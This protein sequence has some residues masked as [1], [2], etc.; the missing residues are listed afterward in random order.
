MR[1]SMAG[2]GKTI[3]L[4]TTSGE[5]WQF[6]TGKMDNAKLSLDDSIY[7]GHD[8]TPRK[9]RQIVIAGRAAQTGLS[10]N[11]AMK[12]MKRN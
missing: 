9:A 5:G 11:W 10:L 8:G 2:D 1:A 7:M 3:L 4:M 6:R 12:L